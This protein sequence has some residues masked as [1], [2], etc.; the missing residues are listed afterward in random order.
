MTTVSRYLFISFWLT[1]TTG[2]ILLIS[3]PCVGFRTAN[4]ISYRVTIFIVQPVCYGF[5]KIP[6]VFLGY[7]HGLLRFFPGELLRVFVLEKQ[8]VGCLFQDEGFRHPVFLQQRLG[9]ANSPG[10]ADGDQLD[11]AGA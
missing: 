4:R 5:L 9:N 7:G 6:P 2:R 11:D 10:V 3:L 8:T 1:T